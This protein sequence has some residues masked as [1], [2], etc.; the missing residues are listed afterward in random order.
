[1]D[2]GC[3]ASSAE[4]AALS[5][6]AL[7]STMATTTTEPAAAGGK[8]PAPLQERPFSK[9]QLFCSNLPWSVNGKVRNVH[10]IHIPNASLPLHPA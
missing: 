6:F 3:V 1:M 2:S 10:K 8:P 5:L 4:Y 9:V 7:S